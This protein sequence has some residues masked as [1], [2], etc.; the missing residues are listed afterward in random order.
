MKQVIVMAAGLGSRLKE[1]TKETPKPLLP[2]NGKPM[3]ET[4]IEYMIQANMDRVVIIVGYLKQKFYY[5]KEKYRDQIEI[6]FVENDR[7]KDFNTIYSMYLARNEFICDSYFTTADNYLLKNLYKNYQDEK[8]F[9]L[10]RP[11]QHFEKEEWTVRLDENYRFLTVD[12][13]GHDGYSYSGV[14]FW[15]KEDLSFIK[16]CLEDVDWNAPETVKMYWDN[17]LLPHLNDFAIH[18]LILKDNSDFYE[19]DDQEDL[20]NLSH[21]L[22]GE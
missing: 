19:V 22:R 8:S 17:T 5:L 18:A 12:L 13:H 11:Y 9:Y 6:V 16:S 21:Y 14:S 2:I 10:L 4:N 7:Y 1:L 15:T 20:E 3:L